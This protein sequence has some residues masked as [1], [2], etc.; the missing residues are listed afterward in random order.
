MLDQGHEQVRERRQDQ[1]Q[2][3]RQVDQA[4]GRQRPQAQAGG[5]VALPARDGVDAGAEDLGGEGPF[6]Q[7]QR[8]DAGGGAVEIEQVRKHE[9]QQV[10]LHQQRRV[11]RELDVRAA[12]HPQ[13]DQPAFLH[14]R[15]DQADDG[16]QRRA[17][18]REDDGQA[19]AG[20]Q[21]P[22]GPFVA[23]I[24]GQQQPR[25]AVPLPVVAD[26]GGAVPDAADDG[27]QRQERAQP[28]EKT[29]LWR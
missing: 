6:E 5:G 20:R 9:V 25:D 12:E 8:Q 21:R 19:Q 26:V 18:Q 22:P 2:A 17:A 11:A 23:A 7:R 29:F 15:D 1:R 10:Q 16:R 27:S 24:A 4:E 14:Q 3:L 28:R 13:R